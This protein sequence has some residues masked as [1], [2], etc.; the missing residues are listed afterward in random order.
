M[1]WTAPKTWTSDLV[2][3]ADFNAQ[4][5]DNLIELKDPPGDFYDVDELADYTTTSTSFTD[6]DA[7]NL[8]LTITT[9][10]GDV[11]IWFNGTFAVTSNNPF[12]LDVDVDGARAAGDDGIISVR[13]SLTAVNGAVPMSFVFWVTGLTAGS[14][15]FKLQ[16][17]TAAG[18]V[19]LHAGAGTSNGNLHPQFGVR[20]VS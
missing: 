9:N 4:I 17:K 16:W 10:G 18:T 12:F 2:T 11:M 15:T 7:T 6:V 5:R 1:A 19:T 13:Q 14:H 3:V 20:E 8:A